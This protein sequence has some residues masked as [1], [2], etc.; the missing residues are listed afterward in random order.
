M[1]ILRSGSS[2]IPANGTAPKCRTTRIK[3]IGWAVAQHKRRDN[4]RREAAR[5]AEREAVVKKNSADFD[6]PACE[7]KNNQYCA[8]NGHEW[9][10]FEGT[11]YEK[12]PNAANGDQVWKATQT[13]IGWQYCRCRSLSTVSYRPGLRQEFAS[14]KNAMIRLQK[15]NKRSKPKKSSQVKRKSHR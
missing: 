7:C 4:A 6:C 3:A 10:G 11:K 15:A 9:T 8:D 12:L 13:K 14:V 1:V 5:E 2:T